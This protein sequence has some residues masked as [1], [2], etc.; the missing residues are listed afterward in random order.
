MAKFSSLRVDQTLVSGGEWFTIPEFNKGE[1]LLKGMSGAEYNDHANYLR[2]EAAKKLMVAPDELPYNVG[3]RINAQLIRELLVVDVRN[4]KD[5]DGN[6]VTKDEFLALLDDLD[7]RT[8]II[9]TVTKYARRV[10]RSREAIAK[11]AVGN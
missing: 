6:E 9:I 3:T 10:G 2:G 8:D 7:Y 5:D 4:L 11:D 1:F